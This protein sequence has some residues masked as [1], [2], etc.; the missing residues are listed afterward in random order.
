MNTILL[1]ITLAFFVAIVVALIVILAGVA[2][3][4]RS[5]DAEIST[6]DSERRAARLRPRD[7]QD[8]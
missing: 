2:Q 4:K 1:Y 8:G 3:A 6:R 5:V 7:L